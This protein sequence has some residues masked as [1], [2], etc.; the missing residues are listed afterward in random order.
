MHQFFFDLSTVPGDSRASIPER[1]LLVSCTKQTKP[2][3][4]SDR[5]YCQDKLWSNIMYGPFSSSNTP[6]SGF[7]GNALVSKH[8]LLV[9]S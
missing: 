9:R 5:V 2:L 6:Q 1:P 4:Q 8:K 3:C 7:E